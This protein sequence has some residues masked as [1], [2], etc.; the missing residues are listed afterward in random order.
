MGGLHDGVQ[1]WSMG[2]TSFQVGYVIG[3][4]LCGLEEASPHCREAA[5]DCT[6]WRGLGWSL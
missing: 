1:G 4:A 3:S 6:F 5:V 2:R